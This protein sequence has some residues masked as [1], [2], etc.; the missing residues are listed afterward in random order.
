MYLIFIY[1]TPETG[2]VTHNT[3]EIYNHHGHVQPVRKNKKNY[4][5][6]LGV[7]IEKLRNGQTDT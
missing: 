2:R 7:Q 4:L 6:E 3:P 5:N 1:L